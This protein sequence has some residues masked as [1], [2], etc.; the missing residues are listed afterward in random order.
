MVTNFYLC[1]VVM[2]IIKEKTLRLYM[3]QSRYSPARISLEAWIYLVR[4]SYWKSPSELHARLRTASIISSR[5]VVFN[6]KGNQ[7]RLV[8]DINYKH[9]VVFI[10]WFGTHEEYDHIDVMTVRYGD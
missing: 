8:V 7:Y 3:S 10:V 9:K 6:I 1:L 4:F 2:R 5:R